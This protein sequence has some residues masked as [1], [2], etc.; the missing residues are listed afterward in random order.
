MNKREAIAQMLELGCKQKQ[1]VKAL[2]CSTQTVVSVRHKGAN[3]YPT[4]EE[5]KAATAEIRK[6]W[7]DWKRRRRVRQPW[8]LES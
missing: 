7:S 4:A 1:I 6:T 8:L 3:S 5:I 2:R